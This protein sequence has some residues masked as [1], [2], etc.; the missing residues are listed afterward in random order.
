[1][2]QEALKRVLDGQNLTCEESAAVMDEIM[3]GACTGAQIGAYLVALRIKGET[4][5]EITGAARVMREK[6][7]RIPAPAD[8]IDTCG[9]G[10]DGQKTFNVST[11]AALV[12]AGAGAKVAK[13]GNRSVSSSSGSS[14]VLEALGV[15]VMAGPETVARC[16]EEAGI[17]FLFAPLLHGAMKH[18]IGPRKEIGVRTIFNILGPLTNPAGARRQ[19]LGVYAADLVETL[20]RVLQALGAERVIVVHGRDGLDEIT[21]SEKTDMAV[22]RDGAVETATIAPEE[23]G[24]KRAPIERMRVNSPEESAAILRDV[25]AGGKGPARDMVLVNA[26]AALFAADLAADIAEGIEKA[27]EAVDRGKASASLNR[28][29]EVSRVEGR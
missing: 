9:T 26:G 12:A 16:I 24:L 11:A 18:A 19:L 20:A 14:Q 15:N 6:A 4:V 27:R 1:M 3:S 29:I 2:I 8:V 10:G 5:D 23:F 13:H 21:L 7:T 28:L 25:L 17:G 22:L